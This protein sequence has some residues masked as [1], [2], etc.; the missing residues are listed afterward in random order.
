MSFFADGGLFIGLYLG[1]GDVFFGS[2]AL[3]GGI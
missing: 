3:T 2:P 1:I